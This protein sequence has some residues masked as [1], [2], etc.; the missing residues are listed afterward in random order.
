MG[1]PIQKRAISKDIF[2]YALVY[3]CLISDTQVR[4]RT[5]EGYIPIKIRTVTDNKEDNYTECRYYKTGYVIGS[6]AGVVFVGGE[7]EDGTTRLKGCIPRYLR[8]LLKMMG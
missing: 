2:S 4:S 8:G 1:F 6:K 5:E 3:T 7:I